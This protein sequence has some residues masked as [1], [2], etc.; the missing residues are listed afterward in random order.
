MI[1][2]VL[3]KVN[4]AS[5]WVPHETIENPG[6]MKLVPI[7]C[8][9]A[10]RGLTIRGWARV[11]WIIRLGGAALCV[12]LILYGAGIVRLPQLEMVGTIGSTL[13]PYT[14]ALVG[15]MAFLETAAFAGLIVPGETVV[16]LGGV[17]AGRGDV[18]V[19]ALVALT[20]FCAL[21]GDATGYVLGRRLG[22]RSWSRTVPRCI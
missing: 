16:I 12:A 7:A 4:A 14:Y 10:V 1:G 6:P 18:D 17:I 13:G 9:V 19:L 22:R 15:V 11:G 8:A 21:S 2:V 5:R 20:W 3:A